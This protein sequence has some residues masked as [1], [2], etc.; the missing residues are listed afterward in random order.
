MKCFQVDLIIQ[1]DIMIIPQKV[2]LLFQIAW[3]MMV[4][5][6]MLHLSETMLSHFAVILL[7]YKYQIASLVLVVQPLFNVEVT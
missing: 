7:K 1:I 3:N 2:T 5:F 6:I 4:F